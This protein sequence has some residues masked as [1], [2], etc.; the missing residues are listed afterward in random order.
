V[1]KMKPKPAKP[2]KTRQK[3]AIDGR[4][5]QT[6]QKREKSVGFFAQNTFWRQVRN[7]GGF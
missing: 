1:L 7:N 3:P 5:R 4:T 2:A 6:R